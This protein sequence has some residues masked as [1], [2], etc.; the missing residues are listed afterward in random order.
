V[1]ILLPTLNEDTA[2]PTRRIMPEP[3]EP[4]IRVGERGK[5][6]ALFFHVNMAK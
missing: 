2:A 5:F 4:G 1:T 3:S 6:S